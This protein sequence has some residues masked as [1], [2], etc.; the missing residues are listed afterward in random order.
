MNFARNSGEHHSNKVL[1]G[2]LCIIPRKWDCQKAV[3]GYF[4]FGFALRIEE[5]ISRIPVDVLRRVIISVHDRLTEYKQRNGGHLEDITSGMVCCVS[6]CPV[7]CF[8][9]TDSFISAN[10]KV[11]I[12]L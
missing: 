4:I 10:A 12:S 6:F 9:T 5:E 2:R 7:L 11:C 3:S 1:A 8:K